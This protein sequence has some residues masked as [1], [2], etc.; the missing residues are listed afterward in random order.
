MRLRLEVLAQK[1]SVPAGRGEDAR[2]HLLAAMPEDRRGCRGRQR[3]LRDIRERI[4]VADRL[5]R[6][7]LVRLP[8]RYEEEPAL[9]VPYPKV[10]TV[11][12]G[13]PNGEDLTRVKPGGRAGQ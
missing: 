13:H 6:R 11:G 8:E 7:S 4:P 1:D 10:P 9:G 3:Q 12:N 2:W 5:R